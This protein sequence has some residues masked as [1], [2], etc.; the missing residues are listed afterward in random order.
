MLQR[1]GN[2]SRTTRACLSLLSLFQFVELDNSFAWL[3]MLLVQLS[4]LI[5]LGFLLLPVA[6]PAGCNGSIHP[7]EKTWLVLSV[8]ITILPFPEASIH[9][10]FTPAF[11]SLHR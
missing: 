4:Y 2:K 6:V 7:I 8:L 5:L 3:K 10:D 1:T 9:E 11:C